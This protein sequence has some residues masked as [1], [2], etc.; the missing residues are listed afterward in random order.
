ME[1]KTKITTIF[2]FIFFSGTLFF[3][4][5]YKPYI[6][7]ESV[8]PAATISIPAAPAPVAEYSYAPEMVVPGEAS[9][10]AKVFVLPTPEPTPDS[11]PTVF[12][13]PERKLISVNVVEENRV[14]WIRVCVSAVVLL[15]S[16]YM[17]LIGHTGFGRPFSAGDLKWAYAMIGT[18]VGFWLR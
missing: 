5:R 15:S 3:F 6:I 1:N 2:I 18:V 12:S 11:K 17:I 13:V 8:E 16:L 7:S 14:F 4:G 10:S 9:R